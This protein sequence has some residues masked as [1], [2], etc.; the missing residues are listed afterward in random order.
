MRTCRAA[1]DDGLFPGGDPTVLG[2]AVA[3]LLVGGVEDLL[4][5]EDPDAIVDSVLDTRLRMLRH[6]IA[7]GVR[8]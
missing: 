7:G 8:G 3:Q 5:H 4:R 1:I 6:G 2:M